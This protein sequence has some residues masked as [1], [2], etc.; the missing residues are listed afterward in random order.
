M[1]EAVSI[2]SLFSLFLSVLVLR[3]YALQIFSKKW[4][5]PM[6]WLAYAFVGL[7]LAWVGRTLYWDVYWP[8]FQNPELSTP[9]VNFLLN[10][11]VIVTQLCALRAKYLTIPHPDRNN[12]NTLTAALYPC[13]T[14]RIRNRK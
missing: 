11:G 8:V 6:V 1:V 13:G 5:E 4:G 3:G 12:Y 14:W 10:S 9:L 7:S 2:T